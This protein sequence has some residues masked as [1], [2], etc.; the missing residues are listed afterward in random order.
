[1]SDP[2]KYRTKEEV[3][4]YKEKDPI[5]QIKDKILTNNYASAEQLKEIEQTVKEIVREAVEF[6]ENSSLPNE[7]ELY[8]NIYVE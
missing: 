6:A 4:D 8:T 2:A 5:S 7:S 1:M 3:E